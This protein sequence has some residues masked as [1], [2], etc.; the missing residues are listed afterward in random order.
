MR[1]TLRREGG[2]ERQMVT[3]DLIVAGNETQTLF[4]I[5]RRRKD[6]RVEIVFIQMVICK[7]RGG[8]RG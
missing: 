1:E 3:Q 2:T 7:K 8:W 4:E 6:G 5:R